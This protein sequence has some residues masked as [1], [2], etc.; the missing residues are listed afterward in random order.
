VYF[1][2]DRTA[3]FNVMVNGWLASKTTFPQKAGG[4]RVRRRSLQGRSA[5][6]HASDALAASGTLGSVEASGGVQRRKTAIW[7]GLEVIDIPLPAVTFC[8]LDGAS[9]GKPMRL[10]CPRRF[11]AAT[12]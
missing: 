7:I 12:T 4:S 8:G 11:A 3:G 5:G 10:H 1:L 2:V 9:F 6:Q